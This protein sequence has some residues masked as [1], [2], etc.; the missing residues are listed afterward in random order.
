MIGREEVDRLRQRPPT[1]ESPVLSVYLDVDQARAANLNREF[2]AAM[3]ARLRAIGQGLGEAERAAFHAD[4]ERVRRFVAAYRPQAKTLVLFA[5]DSADLFWSGELQVALPT[6]VRREPVPYM[7]PLLEAIDQHEP[8]GVILADKERARLFAVFLGEIGEEGEVLAVG[9]VRHKKASGTDHLRS[10]MHFQRQDDL[11]VHWHLRQVAALMEDV[12]RPYSIG[13]LIL[14]GPVEATS[15]LARVL[16]RALAE[17]VVGTLRL[18]IDTPADGVLRQT[19]EIA[20]RAERQ[21]E[22][23]R[24]AEVL[25]HGVVGLE[26]TLVALQ[27]GRLHILVYAD[28]LAVRGGECPRCH[29]LFAAD[30]SR[31]CSYCCERLQSLD[32][33]VGRTVARAREWGVRPEKVDGAPAARLRKAGGIGALLRF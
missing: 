1:P 21:T 13:R 22:E 12:A 29:A 14:A 30:S 4:A 6:D 5:D 19:L 26:A 24:V 31:A 3:K 16:S 28:R 25:D 32:D 18:P 9:E 2:E 20:G 10:Q 11:H 17:R 15:E 27:E 7:R 23:K 8:Y 33:V